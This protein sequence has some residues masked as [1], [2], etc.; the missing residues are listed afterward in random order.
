MVTSHYAANT[1]KTSQA[2]VPGGGCVAWHSW[3]RASA[4][5]SG[6][7]H[8]KMHAGSRSWRSGGIWAICLLL[9]AL[10]F[11]FVWPVQSA[12]ADPTVGPTISVGTALGAIAVDESVHRIYVIDEKTSALFA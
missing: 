7:G 6:S 8:R 11:G 9:A 10:V 4:R 5:A 12:V 3:P 1:P 2:H